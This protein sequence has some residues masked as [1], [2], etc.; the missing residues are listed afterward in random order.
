MKLLA[1]LAFLGAGHSSRTEASYGK[2]VSR[3]LRF[4]RA[5]QDVEGGIGPRLTGHFI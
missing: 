5:L 1:L 3:G 2:T 4:L